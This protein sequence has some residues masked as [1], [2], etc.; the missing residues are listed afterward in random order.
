MPPRLCPPRSRRC[1]Q[2]HSDDEHADRHMLTHLVQFTRKVRPRAR[3]RAAL[4]AA[5]AARESAA[6]AFGRV[7]RLGWSLDLNPPPAL[8]R[9]VATCR[10]SHARR[11]SAHVRC[12]MLASAQCKR[13]RSAEAF[14]RHLSS[15]SV[16]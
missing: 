13:A 4:C 6:F 11:H 9:P 12:R 15:S 14:L 3:A 7:E 1:A 10:I 16:N 2:A 5:A 8:P